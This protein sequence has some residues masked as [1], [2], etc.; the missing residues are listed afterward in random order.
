MSLKK[1]RTTDARVW[2]TEV[3]EVR[4]SGEAVDDDEYDGLSVDLG[5]A[6]N[7]VHRDIC[8]HLGQHVEWLEETS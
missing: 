6:L 2:L 4:V 1:V 5:K 8:P 3:N 7:Q